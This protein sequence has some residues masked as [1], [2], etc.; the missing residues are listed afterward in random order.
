MAAQY[1][2]PG[3][4]A[5]VSATPSRPADR[6]RR[7]A[8][9]APPR[10]PQRTQGRRLAAARI[11][12]LRQH[13]SKD[14]PDSRLK[15]MRPLLS[16]AGTLH[17]KYRG[18]C[19]TFS[20]NPAAL[21]TKLLCLA[22]SKLSNC[23]FETVGRIEVKD[24][25]LSQPMYIF[26]EIN[27]DTTNSN[28]QTALEVVCDLTSQTAREITHVISGSTEVWLYLLS[29]IR[30]YLLL[31]VAE[32][33]DR[34]AKG[35]PGPNALDESLLVDE[36]DYESVEFPLAT[37]EKPSSHSSLSSIHSNSQSEA[38]VLYAKPLP[39]HQRSGSP[40]RYATP[41]WAFRALMWWETSTC[42]RNK[43]ERECKVCFCHRKLRRSL[44]EFA[45]LPHFSV[46]RNSEDK[47][48]IAC[49]I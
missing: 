44:C 2:S 48:V 38:T 45:F 35:L 32:Y 34:K 27:C 12:L 17:Q 24:V 49:M 4:G 30:L 19:L 11:R 40:L 3:D 18:A 31:F 28:C 29:R 8:Q 26:T 1:G 22:N 39:R 14:S 15:H 16:V 37:R 20:V 42:Y 10:R 47:S 13:P 25:T 5:T 6:P 23:C 9:R 36:G 7:P 46:E 21:C 43:P 41:L 33:L